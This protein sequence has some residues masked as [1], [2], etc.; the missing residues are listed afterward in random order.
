MAL[1]GKQ[2]TAVEKRLKC[3]FYG[4]AGSGKTTAAVQF[5]RP[6]LIDTE[7]GAENDQYVKMLKAAGGAYFGAKEGANDPDEVIKEV[8]SL[9]SEKH[10]FAT[11]IIDPLTTL[12]NDLLDKAA[13]KVGTDFGKHKGPAGRKIKH[14]LN[15]L[16]MVDMNV[17]ITSHAKP[18]WVRAKDA[19]GKDTVAQEGQTFDCLSSLDYLFDLVIEVGKRGKDRVG[20]VRKSRMETFPESEVFPFSYSE[21]ADRYGRKVLERDAV[22]VNFPTPAQVAEL[23]EL[24]TLRKDAEELT[25]KWL[26]K[27]RAEKFSEM[28]AESVEKC[29]AWLREQKGVAA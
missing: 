10:N 18:N 20:T 13:D 11:V 29:I 3:L 22:P 15:L 23:T 5:P 25:D 2:P 6:Y 28:P 4:P 17:I 12:Y 24:V 16:L 1:R 27:A 21:V 26:T 19:N 8:R 7:R 14:L 9:I